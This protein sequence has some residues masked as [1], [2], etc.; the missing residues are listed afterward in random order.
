[1]QIIK[2]R[3]IIETTWLPNQS[4]GHTSSDLQILTLKDWLEKLD[5]DRVN[6]RFE[7]LP[8]VLLQPDEDLNILKEW[9]TEIPVIAINV[10]NFSD[11]RV[12][13]LAIELR[14]FSRYTGEIRAIGAIYDNLS[15]MEQCGFN[16]FEL[17]DG[18]VAEEAIRYF[19]EIG[20]DY[21]LRIPN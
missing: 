18:L 8:G 15:M 16:A 1:M 10:G 19:D 14:E 17:Q 6:E 13:S 2:N 11:G 3:E 5:N 7:R 12:Y 4:T 9:L 21:S 20:Y